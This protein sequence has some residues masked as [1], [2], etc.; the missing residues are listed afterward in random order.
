MEDE[1]S[2]DTWIS[3]GYALY[4][5][6]KYNQAILHYDKAIEID[7]KN[8]SVWIHKGNTLLY[9][10]GKDDEAKK[11]YDRAKELEN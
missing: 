2:A 1:N 9:K 6:G 3:K 10:L 7:P 11:C 5:L 4:R 8:S